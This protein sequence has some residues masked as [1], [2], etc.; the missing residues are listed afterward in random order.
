MT[1]F[2]NKLDFSLTKK[3]FKMMSY[4]ASVWR[5]FPKISFIVPFL[6][7]LSFV[8]CTN[9]GDTPKDAIYADIDLTVKGK[10][11][12]PYDLTS[13]TWFGPDGELYTGQQNWYFQQT[14]QL[15]R[16]HVFKDGK[17]ISMEL[18]DYEGERFSFS[19]TNTFEEVYGS[20]LNRTEYL[21]SQNYD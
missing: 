20:G 17:E 6:A 10:D 8:F 5:S 9:F 14:G 15:H 18:F 2:T 4:R 11:K 16:K 13:R 7:I 12:H 21:T 19:V 3:R 1:Q